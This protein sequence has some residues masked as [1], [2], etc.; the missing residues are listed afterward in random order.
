MP[1][2]IEK[3][4]GLWLE[5]ITK[6]R[7]EIGNYS[8]CPFAKEL[9]KVKIAEKLTEKFDAVE[10]VKIAASALGGNLYPS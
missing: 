4:L 7:S 8:I 6:P 9:P 3:H 1:E 10:L 2:N 5:R